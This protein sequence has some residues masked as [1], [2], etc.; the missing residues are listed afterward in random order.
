MFKGIDKNFWGLQVSF[1]MWLIIKNV[2]SQKMSQATLEHTTAIFLFKG[3]ISVDVS[4]L[5]FNC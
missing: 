3:I 5:A 4:Q 2:A 1:L